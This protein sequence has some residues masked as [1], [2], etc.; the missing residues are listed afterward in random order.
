[1]IAPGGSLRAA[2]VVALEMW[3]ASFGGTNDFGLGSA[4]AMFLFVLVVP[5]MI[6]NI[7]R[8]RAET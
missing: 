1:V 8:F 7:R 6:L 3:R 5:F 4:L 2:N